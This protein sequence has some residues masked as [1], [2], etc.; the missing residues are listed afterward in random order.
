MRRRRLCRGNGNGT[1][2]CWTRVGYAACRSECRL[3]AGAPTAGGRLGKRG[4]GRRCLLRAF[5]NEASAREIKGGA[6]R[7]RCVRV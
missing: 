5:V 1:V 4:R 3:R 2:H 7:D 6:R